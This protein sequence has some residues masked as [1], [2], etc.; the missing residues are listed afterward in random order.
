MLAALRDQRRALLH[1]LF[2]MPSRAFALDLM[3]GLKNFLD[4]KGILNSGKV[5]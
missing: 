5:L 3:R 1:G 4:P 2:G